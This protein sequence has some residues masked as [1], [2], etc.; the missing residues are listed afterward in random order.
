MS[1]DY[2]DEF[3]DEGDGGGLIAL[4]ITVL[5]MWCLIVVIVW[6]LR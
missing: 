6:A 4:L 2:D 3:E 1:D 5:A